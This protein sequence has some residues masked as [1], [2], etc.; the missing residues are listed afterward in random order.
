MNCAV[1]KRKTCL[2]N[3]NLTVKQ[4]FLILKTFQS[5]FNAKHFMWYIVNFHLQSVTYHLNGSLSGMHLLQVEK[6]II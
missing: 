4:K 1:N 2:L 6:E 3:P 5:V